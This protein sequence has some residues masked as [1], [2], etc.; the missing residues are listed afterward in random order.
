M[1]RLSYL[2]LAG[3][4]AAAGCSQSPSSAS[5]TSKADAAACRTR[6]D[7]IYNQQNRFLLSERN[8]TDSPYSTSGNP[9]VTNQRLSQQYGRDELLDS[10]LTSIAAQG[11]VDVGAG[12]PAAAQAPAPKAP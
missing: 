9:G 12:G 11:K 6:T 5:R 7:A 10:C 3:V 2:L 8:T 1:I 4:L